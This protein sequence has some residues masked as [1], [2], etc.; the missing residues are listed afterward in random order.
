MRYASIRSM[1]VTNGDGIRV[2]VFFQGCS[3]HCKNCFNQEAW[4]FNGGKELTKEIEDKIIFEANKHYIKGIS[5]LG[6]EPMQQPKEELNDFLKRLKEEVNKPIYVWTGYTFDEIPNKEALQYLDVVID[7]K[8]VE[9][10]KDY[11]LKWRG[12]S[13]QNIYHKINGVWIKE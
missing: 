7:G 6:G 10:L 8:F 1:D 4:D 2:S 9:E 11:K 12:S 3:H 13:N 5:L